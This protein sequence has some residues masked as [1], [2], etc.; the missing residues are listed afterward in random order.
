MIRILHTVLFICLIV[1]MGLAAQEN[2]C[3][4]TSNRKAKK[5]YDSAMDAIRE[6]RSGAAVIQLQK[7]LELD[8]EYADALWRLGQLHFNQLRG[9]ESEYYLKQL[10]TLCPD[11]NAEAYFLLARIAYGKED[12]STAIPHLEK[13]LSDVDKIRSDRDYDNAVVMLEQAKFLREIRGETRPFNPQKVK[14]ISTDD[15]EYLAIISPD[16]EL[17]FFTRRTKAQPG[18]GAISWTE[19]Y[20]EEFMM[21]TRVNG[22]FDRGEAMP[23][24][25]NLMGNEGGA[26]ITARNDELYFTICSNIKIDNIVYNNC[27]IYYTRN[28]YDQWNPLE[29]LDING[30]S[31]ENTWE[32]QP[33]ISSD[34]KTLYFAS[35]RPGGYGGTDIWVVEKDANNEWGSPRN[36][37]P[38]INT[39]GNEKTPFIHTDSQTLYFSSSDWVDEKD[40]LHLGHKGL[41]GYDIFYTRYSNAIWSKPVNIGYPINSE[42]DDLSFFVSTDGTTGYFAS[43]KIEGAGGYDLFGFDLYHEARPQKVLF[44]KGEVKDENDIPV[45]DTK[46]ELK[47]TITEEIINVEV[48]AITARY[49]A[50]AVFEADFVL[51]VKKPDHI[52][53]SR[54]IDKDS[55]TFNA[56]VEINFEIEKVET[57]KSYQLHDIYFATNSAQLSAKSLFILNEFIDFLKDNNS[58]RVDIH[59]HTDD[60][61]DDTFNMDL[62]KRRAQAV[63]D[64]LVSKGIPSR[65]LSYKGFGKTRPVADNSTEEGRAKNR[66]TEFVISGR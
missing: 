25:F 63:Y 9:R 2:P 58:I 16:G 24:P 20:K 5:S 56:P 42:A 29:K 59:G 26:T 31:L 62:S 37:G 21:A 34:G 54:F 64:Y 30:I 14:D 23:A 53:Q 35:D 47:N 44:V 33:S 27:D 60:V 52:Y 28:V 40:S 61:G 17:A 66:R 49:V 10:I 50:I 32:S 38:R 19:K 51:T 6:R 4:G 3:K 7:A 39:P 22:H 48:D 43:N 36:L 8:E 15:D 57:G 46:I 11:Y 1:P 45:P 18:M 55:A 12:F 65:R 13:F 41:G